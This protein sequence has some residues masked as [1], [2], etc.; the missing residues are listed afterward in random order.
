M[1]EIKCEKQWRLIKM[2]KTIQKN[3][4]N[5]PLKKFRAGA[6]EGVIWANKRKRE[7]GTEI[8]FKTATL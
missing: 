7:D 6:I 3:T 8:E 5:M 1:F 2:E 4:Q